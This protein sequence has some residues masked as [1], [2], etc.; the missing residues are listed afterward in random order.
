MQT[1]VANLPTRPAGLVAVV[2]SH[3]FTSFRVVGLP[4]EF[5][6]DFGW[7]I[8]PRA[9]KSKVAQTMGLTM[10]CQVKLGGRPLASG[11][12]TQ[13]AQAAWSGLQ[14]ALLDSIP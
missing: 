1:G 2:V 6:A 7:S 14:V 13:A 3:E 11:T 5:H 12:I 4:S 9:A 10:S 8:R